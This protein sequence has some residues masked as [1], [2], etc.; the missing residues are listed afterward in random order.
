MISNRAQLF[1]SLLSLANGVDG[2]DVGV[3]SR[4]AHFSVDFK[5]EVNAAYDPLLLD[6]D[7]ANA[8]NETALDGEGNEDE[9]N[10]ELYFGLDFGV[11]Q[12]LSA[13]FEEQQVARIK[14]TRAYLQQEIWSHGPS[15]CS[16]KVEECSY[17]T[18]AGECERASAFMAVNCAPMCR[19]CQL[20]Q[21]NQHQPV[22]APSVVDPHCPVDY[23]SNAWG[24]GDLHKM[25]ETHCFG[26]SHASV[27]TQSLVATNLG[28]RR[29]R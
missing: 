8:F 23:C 1:L 9:F 19:M 27:R 14:Q 11:P 17:Y 22:S 21:H 25:F 18:V 13:D 15:L 7:V 26:S 24:P 3:K 6:A 12:T 10:E 2:S 16:N 28:T 29:Y 4:E 20:D 5:D